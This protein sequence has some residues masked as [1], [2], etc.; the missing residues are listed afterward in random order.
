MY[1]TRVGCCRAALLLTAALDRSRVVR[2]C[3]G[4]RLR[5]TWGDAC[6]GRHVEGSACMPMLW[7]R[8]RVLHKWFVFWEYG[9]YVLGNSRYP[10]G[11]EREGVA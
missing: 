10:R 1:K 5:K 3:F 8:L 7:F 11:R 9:K 2:S 6:Q 4:R